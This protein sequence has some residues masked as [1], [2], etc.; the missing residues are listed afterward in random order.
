MYPQDF[1]F[2]PKSWQLPLQIQQLKIDMLEIKEKATEKGKPAP[3]FI[4]K[5]SDMA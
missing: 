1:S 5:P 4:V 3:M 2:F